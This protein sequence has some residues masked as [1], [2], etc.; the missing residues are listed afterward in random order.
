M[1][2][3][4]GLGFTDGSD[5]ITDSD[6][7]LRDFGVWSV[8]NRPNPHDNACANPPR[9]KNAPTRPDLVGHYLRDTINTICGAR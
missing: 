6:D 3:D 4:D 7:T 5:F 9:Q 1:G 2:V 8:G